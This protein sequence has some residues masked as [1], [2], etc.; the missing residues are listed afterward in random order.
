MVLLSHKWIKNAFTHI[1]SIACRITIFM[2]ITASHSQFKHP[3]RDEIYS[4]EAKRWKWFDKPPIKK[5]KSAIILPLTADKLYQNCKEQ[6]TLLLKYSFV[7]HAYRVLSS[8]SGRVYVPNKKNIISLHTESNGIQWRYDIYVCIITFKCHR[9]DL[10]WIAIVF[11]Y[12]IVL[13]T[14]FE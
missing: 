5:C 2:S 11:L 3:Y 4:W 6:S 8:H 13:V 10:D 14:W 1:L 12:N 9:T 7:Y